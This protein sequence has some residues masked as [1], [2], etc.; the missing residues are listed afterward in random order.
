MAA[1]APGVE[2]AA[3]ARATLTATRGWLSRSSTH[4]PAY[5][6]VREGVTQ[7]FGPGA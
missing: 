4:C 2:A 5:G 1:L 3:L 7:L 6:P